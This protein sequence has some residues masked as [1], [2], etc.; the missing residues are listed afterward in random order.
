[1]DLRE[2]SRWQGRNDGKEIRHMMGDFMSGLARELEVACEAA[3]AAGRHLRDARARVRIGTFKEGTHNYATVQDLEAERIIVDRIRRNFPDDA[4]LAEEA[5]P[6]AASAERLWI[7]DP[8]D[9]TRNYANHLPFFSVSIALCHEHVPQVGVVYAPCLNDELYSAVRGQGAWLDGE[10]LVM[11]R[12]EVDL[13]SSVVGTGFSY[14]RGPILKRAMTLYE[15]VLNHA[16][17]VNRYGSAALD[18]C[19]VAAGRL[20]AYYEAGLKPWDVAAGVLIVNEAGGRCLDHAGAAVDVLARQDGR[21]A[22]DILAAKNA[23]I[24]AAMLAIIGPP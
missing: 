24:A 16:T 9:G 21:F 12:P 11:V 8:L 4:I 17:D 5:F 1:M 3:R 13:A 22:V 6:E 7:V 2:V 20:G 15:R 18:L 14:D 23:A 10:P 19:Y